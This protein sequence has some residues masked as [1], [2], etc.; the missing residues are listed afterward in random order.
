MPYTGGFPRAS[1]VKAVRARYDFAVDGGAVGEIKLTSGTPIPA[2]ALILGGFV[3]VD[4]ALTGVTN[5]AAQVKVQGADDII[6]GAA[7][8]GAPWSTTGRKDV[9]P[10]FT[11]SAT[12]KTT[13]ARD[14]VLVVET[15]ALTAGVFDVV[16]FYVELPD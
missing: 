16:L 1:E 9:I 3:E 10:D 13:A 11:G 4:T 12:I 5:A 8:T 7:V 2:N 14:I 6:D 15:A